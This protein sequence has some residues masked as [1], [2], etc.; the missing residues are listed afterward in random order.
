MDYAINLARGIRIALIQKMVDGSMLSFADGLEL[1]TDPL[2]PGDEE[3]RFD[4]TEHLV[5]PKCHQ[6]NV[7]QTGEY[8]CMVCGLPTV[9]DAKKD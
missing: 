1:L 5:C 4:D 8:P 3:T 9:H 2:T 6:A 7:G